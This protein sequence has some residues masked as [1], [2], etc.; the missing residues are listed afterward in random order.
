[1]ITF[2]QTIQ[3]KKSLIYQNNI[4]VE[5]T[6]TLDTKEDYLRHIDYLTTSD[7]GNSPLK[8]ANEMGSWEVKLTDELGMDH[9]NN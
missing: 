4:E 2:Y 6:D 7:S 1:M 9:Q 3:K 8:N 5:I